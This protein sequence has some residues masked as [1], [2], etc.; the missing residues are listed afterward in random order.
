MS[1][2]EYHSLNN[3]LPIIL[4]LDTLKKDGFCRSI[5]NWHENI[6]LLYCIEGKGHT[7]I[8]SMPVKMEE[9]TVTVVNSGMMHYTTADS[10]ILKYYCLIIDTTFLQKLGLDVERTILSEYIADHRLS[11][12]FNAIVTEHS[13]KKD[14]YENMIKSSVI[15][16]M[17]YIF[18]SYSL[19][20]KQG[21]T[22]NAVKSSIKYIC[23]HFKE[24][25][26][27][28]NVAEYVGFSRFHFSRRFKESVGF[29]IKEYIQ[30]M[31]CREAEDMLRTHKYT[32]SEVA[33]VC[34][35]SDVSYFT[36]T[37]K[38]F[39]GYLPSKLKR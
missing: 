2:Y 38:R 17:S 35:F 9:G 3:D 21:R 27:V 32:V 16:L 26:S 28:S 23:E 37:F 13:N 1:L 22:D 29:T 25:I 18:R 14:F 30:I 19:G 10:D 31:R 20:E 4:H 5:S 33:T 6:E 15:S 12:Y 36:K 24:D 8:D 7:I 11:E 39:F 34:G